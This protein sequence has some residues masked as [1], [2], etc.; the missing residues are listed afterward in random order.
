M[1]SMLLS[2][3]MLSSIVLWGVGIYGADAASGHNAVNGYGVI[4]WA[5]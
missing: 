1:K 2:L 4:A 5:R 3:T